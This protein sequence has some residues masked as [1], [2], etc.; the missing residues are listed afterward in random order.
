MSN[1]IYA[2][3]RAKTEFSDPKMFRA[4]DE[5]VTKNGKVVYLRLW[6]EKS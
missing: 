1:S 2:P 5:F 6:D 4:G 3:R